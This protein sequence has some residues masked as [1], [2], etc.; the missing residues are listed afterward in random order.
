M[1]RLESG[2]VKV[3]RDLQPIDEVIGV[4]LSRLED[5]LRDH[6]VR[7]HLEKDLP[8]VAIDAVLI[9]QVLVNLLENALRYTPP[10][11]PID[12]SVA[13]S[14]GMLTVEV[15]DT[16]PGVPPGSEE[17]IFDKFYRAEQR[18]GDGGV[19]LGLTICR[20]IMTAHGGRI[21][22]EARPGGGA[23]FRFTLPAVH[24]PPPPDLPA[25]QAGAV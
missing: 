10:G 8:L 22:A 6:P 20:A 14:E 23:S 9:E 1:T 13:E 4:A 24:P 21:W 7:T 18:P 2:A 25:E 3:R 19:G 16:G 5:R 11:T 17:R 12:L 15:A